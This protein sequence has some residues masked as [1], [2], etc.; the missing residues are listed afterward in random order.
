MENNES[1]SNSVQDQI[2]EDFNKGLFP[3][4]KRKWGEE[5]PG[6]KAGLFATCI[7]KEVL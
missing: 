6:I 5:Q 7:N 4:R 2:P 3:L 1:G